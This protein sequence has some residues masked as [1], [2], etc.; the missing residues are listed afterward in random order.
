MSL[1]PVPID[2]NGWKLLDRGSEVLCDRISLTTAS[3][4]VSFP[5]DIKGCACY[6]ESG[7]V[8]VRG[9]S[10]NSK[11]Y[12]DAE[13]AVEGSGVVTI[14]AT[15]HG[16]TAND[17]VTFYGPTNYSGPY[18]I[19]AVTSDTFDIVAD[20]EA[21]TFSVTDYA[22]G[23]RDARISNGQSFSVPV[24]VVADTTVFTLSSTSTAVVSI[25]AWR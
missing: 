15:A 5:E 24:A 17:T 6:V 14:P 12:L 16:L 23:Y 2:G 8:V 1:K 7:T 10:P 9:T 25:L 4:D 19:D 20:Y 13:A 21:E 18:T 22:V 11:V 3:L